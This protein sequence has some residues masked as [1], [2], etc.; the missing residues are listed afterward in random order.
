MYSLRG[1]STCK[2]KK[3]IFSES[4]QCDK[5]DIFQDKAVKEQTLEIILELTLCRNGLGFSALP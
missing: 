4:Y 3:D 1:K 5:L 2:Q